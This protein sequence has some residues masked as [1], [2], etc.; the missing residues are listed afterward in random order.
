MQ[1]RYLAARPLSFTLFALLL[2]AFLPV[3]HTPTALTHGLRQGTVHG[4]RYLSTSS[5]WSGYAS[6][7]TTYTDVKGTWVQPAVSCSSTAYSAF[8]VGIDGDGTSS[9]EQLGTSSDCRGSTPTYYGWWEMYP[10]PSNTISTSTYPVHVGDTLTAEVHYN[11]SNSYTLSMTNSTRGWTFSTNQTSSSGKR[12]SAE[13]IAEAPSTSSGSLLPL[14]NFGTVQF[15][16]C[17][18]NNSAISA[19]PNPD[20]ITMG[21][22]GTTKAT[23]SGLNGA[24]SGFSV[25]WKHS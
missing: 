23:T 18:A 21:S 15:S 24:G 11:G 14:A 1:T 8:W 22:G 10:H 7:G 6:T 13:W 25:T 4:S 17:T 5:N 12:G 20:A 3:V 9:V 16:N 2:I 19:N